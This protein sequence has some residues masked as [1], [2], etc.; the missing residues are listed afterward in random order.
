MKS[1][2]HLFHERASKGHGSSP[3]Y[4]TNFFAKQNNI[5]GLGAL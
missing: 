5:L 1:S 3:G 4:V 2:H